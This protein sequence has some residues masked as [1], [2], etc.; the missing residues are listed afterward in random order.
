MKGSI[1][2][3]ASFI[4]PMIIV[5]TVIIIMYSFYAHDRLSCKSHAYRA[6]VVSHY[7]SG[8][9]PVPSDIEDGLK[10]ICLLSAG[11]SVS[12]DSNKECISVTDSMHNTLS[13][14]FTGYERCSFVRKYYTLF[15]LVK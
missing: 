6:L 14:Y 7:S 15:K 9:A 5:F 4:Y 2:I 12:Y 10:D 1:T 13:V 11:Y 3:E 8:T